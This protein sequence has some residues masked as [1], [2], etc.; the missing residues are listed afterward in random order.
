MYPSCGAINSDKE[1]ASTQHLFFIDERGANLNHSPRY[2][3]S[4]TNER[5]YDDRPVAKGERMSNG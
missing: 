2:G 3:R 4:L 1:V 5:A